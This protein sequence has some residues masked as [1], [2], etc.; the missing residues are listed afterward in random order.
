MML[1]I[2]AA[3][4]LVLGIAGVLGFLNE[5]GEAPWS[6]PAARHLRAMKERATIP[7]VYTPITFAE[8]ESLPHHAGAAEDAGIE[9]RSVSLE[10][11]VQMLGR[12]TDGDFHL[13]FAPSLDR[14]GDL[15]PY[16]SAEITSATRRTASR[17]TFE[18]LVERFRPYYGGRTAWNGPP[19]R[20]RVSGWLMHDF[21]YEGSKPMPG[22]PKHLT[23]WEVHPVTKVEVWDDALARWDEVPR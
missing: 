4:T 11:Y 8:M 2:V 13:D 7:A 18:R 21:P 14:D 10:G 23:V 20:V 12:A 5:L 16:L 19:R 3:G 22:W 15:V 17:W 1:R 6:S 9:G